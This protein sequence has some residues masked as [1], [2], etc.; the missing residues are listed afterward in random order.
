M[1]V[2]SGVNPGQLLPE[3][4][5][6]GFGSNVRLTVQSTLSNPGT[7]GR[8][9]MTVFLQNQGGVQTLVVTNGA[10]LPGSE[11]SHLC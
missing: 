1:T 8:M 10:A 4:H 2:A 11:S 6:V 7:G 5:L 3:L 9:G